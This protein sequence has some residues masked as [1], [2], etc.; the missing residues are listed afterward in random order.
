MH[1]VKIVEGVKV[2]RVAKRFERAILPKAGERSN[3][4]TSDPPAGGE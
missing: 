3:I 1:Y 4:L 2:V